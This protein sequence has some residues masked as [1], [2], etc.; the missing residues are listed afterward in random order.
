MPQTRRLRLARAIRSVD[1]AIAQ[2]EPRA[3]ISGLERLRGDLVAALSRDTRNGAGPHV[4][5]PFATD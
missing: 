5:D 3:N 2:L 4:Y 1:E